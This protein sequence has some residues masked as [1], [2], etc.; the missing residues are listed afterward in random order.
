[1]TLVPDENPFLRPSDLPFGFP[2][3][4][5]IRPR[6]L[7]AGVRGRGRR[8]AGR[9]RGDRRGPCRA[10]VREHR[11]GAGALRTDPR[12]G[13]AGLLQPGQL[14]VDRR[15]CRSSSRSWRRASSAHRDEILLDAE[16]LR[17]VDAVHGTAF[18]TRP[19]AD[20]EQV[21]VVERYHQDF[22]R[23]GA[24]LGESERTAPRAQ[25]R[26][27]H[28]RRPSSAT[29]PGRGEPARRARRRT[30]RTSTGSPR[31][32]W[33]P[34]RS[35]RPTPASTATSS[36]CD[37]PRSSRRSRHCA[38]A[39]CVAG[40]TRPPPPAACRGGD[41]GHPR[42]ARRDRRAPRRACRAARLPRPRRLRRRGPDRRHHQGG[43]GD[44]R[45][46][47]RARDGATSTWSATR[48]EQLL[49]EDGI[50]GPVAALGLGLLRGEGPRPRRTTST[51]TRSRPT[52]S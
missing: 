38:T 46:D 8:A 1:M 17:P 18:A 34:R 52:S 11:R 16:P 5:R 29:A 19:G 28:A 9:G 30:L 10:D 45:R 21:R 50:D 25:R 32:L 23:A 42:A 24:A 33:S 49:H 40:S 43:A 44:A 15:R 26:D 22:V 51:P 36:R 47:G 14:D 2:P 27:H 39:R 13:A 4:D 6:A 35:Q 37:C 48:I 3:F 31:T 12:A 41:G 20:P 7:P